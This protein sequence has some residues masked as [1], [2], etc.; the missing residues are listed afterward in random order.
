MSAAQQLWPLAARAQQAQTPVVGFVNGGSSNARR[1]AAFRDGL[2]ETG[3]VEGQNVTVEYHWLDGQYD[4]L[5]SLMA[6]LVRRV[7][8]IATPGSN[9]ASLA[10]KAAT[11]TVP[12][13]FGVGEDPVKLGLVASLARPGGN[14]TGINFFGQEVATKRLGLLHE[15]V[16][17]A[18]RIAVLIN[19]ANAP[20]AEAALRAIPDAA[21]AVGLQTQFLKAGTSEEIEAAFAT[22]L[23]DRADALFVAG[24]AF[25]VGRRVQFATLTARHA[26]PAIY[27][28]RE[29]V[30]AGGLMSYGADDLNRFRQ[31]GIYTGQILRGAK[32][33]DLPVMQSTKFEFIINL[34]TARALG[35][36]VPPTVLARADEVIEQARKFCCSA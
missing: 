23:R 34:V 12:I 25:F 32:P 4:R 13:V 1:A 10:A 14:A 30:E 18:V 11:T 36:D 22:L 24:D 33:A 16:P 21:R 17:K 29:Y 6:D 3:Y 26:I 2:N 35:L 27:S 7:A 28:I 31:A 9:P 19:P 8:V 20:T 15:L 5:P